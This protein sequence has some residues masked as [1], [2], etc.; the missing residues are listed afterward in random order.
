MGAARV[1]PMLGWPWLRVRITADL[2]VP[3]A[4]FRLQCGADGEPFG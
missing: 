1:D 3:W 4:G 2:Q